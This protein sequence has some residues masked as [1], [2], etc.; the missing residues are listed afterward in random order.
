M[1]TLYLSCITIGFLG[2]YLPFLDVCDDNTR[3]C[4]DIKF[5]FVNIFAYMFIFKKNIYILYIHVVFPYIY[6]H[7]RAQFLC[8]SFGQHVRL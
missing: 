3:L 7:N 5:F 6:T 1:A 4:K 2:T 8:S